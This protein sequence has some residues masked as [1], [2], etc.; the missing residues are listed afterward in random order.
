MNRQDFTAYIQH[1]QTLTSGMKEDLLGLAERFSYC[2]SVQVLYMFLLHRV[3]DHEFNFQLR[4]AAAYS[5]SRKK[6]KELIGS[7]TT[8]EKVKLDQ[9][10][11]T[12]SIQSDIESVEPVVIISQTAKPA[13]ETEK[14]PFSKPAEIILT[15]G[16]TSGTSKYKL[17]EQ[18]RKRLNEIDKE[19]YHDKSDKETIID[20]PA[21]HQEADL[22]TDILSKEE[23][24]EKFI[25]EEPRISRPKVSFFKPSEFAEKSNADDIDIV[26][27]TLAILYV[28]QGNISKAR[29]I[30]EKLSLLFPEKSS[31]FATQIEKISNK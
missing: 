1:P 14:P 11:L 5:S 30:Y 3:N 15:Q 31:Y 10:P 27:E 12:E 17:I 6:L 24:I 23:I 4:K 21:M 20:Q 19:N 22:K 28:E 9:Q 25:R 18:V 8:P 2:S 16:Q 29:I 7:I 26:S 13:T